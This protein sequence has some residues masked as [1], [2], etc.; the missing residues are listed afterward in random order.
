ML[1]KPKKLFTRP[2]KSIIRILD[3]SNKENISD[4]INEAIPIQLQPM[5]RI[6][7]KLEDIILEES[8]ES[9]IV[10]ENKFTNL[11]PK[12]MPYNS[13]DT[14]LDYPKD[15]FSTNNEYPEVTTVT[16]GKENYQIEFI[17]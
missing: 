17:V 3:V 7:S 6:Y 12:V 8:N 10:W 2:Q 5:G 1:E 11:S 9:L 14:E 15:S 16:E 13:I 4:Q